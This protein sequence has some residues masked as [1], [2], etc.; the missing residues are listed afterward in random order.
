MTIKQI[1]TTDLRKHN[2][3]VRSLKNLTV[4]E[5]REEAENYRA[6]FAHCCEECK[7]EKGILRI[8]FYWMQARAEAAEKELARR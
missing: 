3:Y 8:P 4:E 7:K 6:D 2:A 5:L 1:L